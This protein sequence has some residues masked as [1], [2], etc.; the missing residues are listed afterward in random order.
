MQRSHLLRWFALAIGLLGTQCIESIS[1]DCTKTLTCEDEQRPVLQPNCQWVYPGGRP[2]TAGPQYDTTTRKWRWPDGTETATQDF[3][4]NLPSADAGADAGPDCRVNLMCDPGQVCDDASGNCYQCVSDAECAGNMAMGD[5]GA[6][7]VCDPASHVCVECLSN[8][9]CS[10]DTQVCRVDLTNSRRNTCVECLDNGDCGGATPI[11]DDRTN[12]C[13]SVCQSAADCTGDDK[14]A[15]NTVRNICVECT[16]GTTCTT[17]SEPLCDVADNQCVECLDDGPCAASGRVCDLETH[18]CVQ[19]RLEVDCQSRPTT[20]V[21]DPDTKQCV[22]CL[23][24]LQ[25]TNGDASR[26]SAS[27]VCTGCTDSSQ[28][29][30]GFQCRTGECVECLNDAHC[31]GGERC[32][33]VRGIC[34][35]CFDTT[36]CTR[37]GQAHCETSQDAPP[38]TLYTCVSCTGNEDC[39]G[40]GK[41]LPPLCDPMRGGGTCSECTVATGTSDCSNN[42]PGLSRCQNG[43]CGPCSVDADCSLFPNTP[44]C[45]PGVGCVACTDNADCTDTAATPICK[46]A[47]AGG[48]AAVN[49]CVQC[50]DNDD[51]RSNAAASVCSDN[52]CVPCA[53]DDDCEL[54]DD[55]GTA[56]GGVG[57]NVCDTGRCVQ[58][59]GAKRTAC[60]EDVCDSVAKRCANGRTFRGAAV[61]EECVSDF[62][63]AT[64]ARCVQQTFAGTPV[65]FFCFP[66]ATGAPATCAGPRIFLGATT[67]PTIDRETPTPTVCQPRRTTCGGLASLANAVECDSAADCGVVNVD[68]G[69]CD[70]AL[71]V[72]TVPCSGGSDC[73]GTCNLEEGACEP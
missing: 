32:E 66:L 15:C 49:T 11:C 56:N 2:W 35:E 60:G 50:L 58:C 72:C 61:C 24:D 5:A 34:V 1:D 26:C 52:V 28:C 55:N 29:E 9:N 40:G 68:D 20:P 10:G 44:A 42:G 3:N 18:S 38:G 37:P 67:S 36:Q 43:T 71:D 41:T 19:C 39:T 25:C 21:C 12:E 54:V 46:L 57:L 30:M 45:L 73:A 6:A 65:G 53:V 14:P 4:C 8:T 48:P 63:C 33:T 27:H 23:N 69:I 22:Q 16:D 13:T 59:T 70:A 31:S 17:E 47:E 51:C 62:E 64:T 7:T